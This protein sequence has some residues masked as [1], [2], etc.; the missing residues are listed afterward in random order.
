MQLSVVIESAHQAATMT[1]QPTKFDP[2]PQVVAK[3][4]VAH[5]KLHR[6]GMHMSDARIT[7]RCCSNMKAVGSEGTRAEVNVY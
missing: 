6:L 1:S 2:T 3:G 4:H 5:S 7:T